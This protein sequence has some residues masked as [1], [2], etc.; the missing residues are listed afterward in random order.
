M[1]VYVCAYTCT[2]TLYVCMY[3]L[4]VDHCFASV[5]HKCSFDVETHVALEYTSTAGSGT[6]WPAANAYLYT[7]ETQ[8]ASVK[9]S[10]C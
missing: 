5:L 6:I 9:N 3:I 8:Q 4:L 10:A 2:R 7:Q 1:F